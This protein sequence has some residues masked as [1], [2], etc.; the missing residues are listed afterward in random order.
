M[1]W[2]ARF[3]LDLKLRRAQ[4]WDVTVTH[5]TEWF[6][7]SLLAPKETNENLY[8]KFDPAVSQPVSLKDFCKHSL[9][10]I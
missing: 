1:E 8:I 10:R 7:G 3:C 9:G 6:M 5:V 2:T 4:S